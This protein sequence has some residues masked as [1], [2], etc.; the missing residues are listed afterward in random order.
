[1][2]CLFVWSNHQSINCLACML[3]AL[4]IFHFHLDSTRVWQHFPSKLSQTLN[5]T[6]LSLTWLVGGDLHVSNARSHA[7]MHTLMHARLHV[8]GCNAVVSMSD[9][10]PIWALYG[11]EKNEWMSIHVCMS[12]TRGY[13]ARMVVWK[14]V[15]EC[16]CP[17]W[18]V[19][20]VCLQ[21]LSSVR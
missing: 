16:G 19:L 6:C 4:L 15:N 3:A 13:R 9:V 21:I 1:M 14:V 10:Q 7:R 20:L 17:C 11:K 2:H 12:C 18:I 5:F 8:N